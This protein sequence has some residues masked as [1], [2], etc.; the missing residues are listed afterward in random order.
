MSFNLY[1]LQKSV[2]LLEVSKVGLPCSANQSSPVAG[3]GKV[4]A[5]DWSAS[6]ARHRRPPSLPR[7]HGIQ[8]PAL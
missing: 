5:A 6:G 1:N 3:G 2:S 8:I 4:H 7:D